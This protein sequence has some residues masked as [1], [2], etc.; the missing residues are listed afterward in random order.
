VPLCSVAPTRRVY[1]AHVSAEQGCQV[2]WPAGTRGWFLQRVFACQHM[3]GNQTCVWH[4]SP[5]PRPRPQTCGDAHLPPRSLQAG[6]VTIPWDYSSHNPLQTPQPPTNPT[7][8][9]KPHNP[10]PPPPY[11]AWDFAH[12][13]HTHL[14]TLC[15]VQHVLQVG[16]AQVCVEQIQGGGLRVLQS[17]HDGLAGRGRIRQL[18]AGSACSRH[19]RRHSSVR[20][21]LNWRC[22]YIHICTQVNQRCK[23]VQILGS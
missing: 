8:P 10:Y 21:S 15:I 11:N 12:T 1:S 20:R 17:G 4:H 22:V 3:L 16:L 5:V 9:C 2:S 14:H 19:G 23:R 13:R 7:A 6:C 18:G